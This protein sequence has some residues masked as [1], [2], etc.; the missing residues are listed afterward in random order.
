MDYIELQNHIQYL[1]S[2]AE[3]DAPTISCY[4]N[5]TTPYRKSLNGQ[6][7]DIMHGLRQ[8]ESAFFWGM[9]GHVE[10]F[11][12]TSVRPETKGVA[13][14]G[15][16][17]RMP[18]FLPLQFDTPFPN[19]VHFDPVPEISMLVEFRNSLFVPAGDGSGLAIAGRAGYVR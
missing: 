16:S 13:I 1:D 17:G 9:L 10:V 2:L 7:R 3:A 6:V 11:L 14:F 5:V 4:L 15:R 19:S 8:E 18:F 12:D